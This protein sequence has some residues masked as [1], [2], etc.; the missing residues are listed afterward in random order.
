MAANDFNLSLRNA[1]DT[2]NIS[3]PTSPI[4]DEQS[5]LGFDPATGLPKFFG[6]D[7]VAAV[8]P[9][10][11]QGVPGVVGPQGPAGAKGDKGEPG[12]SFD[13]EFLDRPVNIA[14]NF[15]LS[16]TRNAWVSYS[17]SLRASTVALAASSESIARLGYS[18]DG[19]STWRYISEAALESTTGLTVSVGEVTDI[20]GSVSG[21]IPAGAVVKIFPTANATGSV[22]LLSYQEVLL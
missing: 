14:T 15:T 22:N 3:R 12:E 5:L 13:L 19:G 2:A 6:F 18:M 21:F 7:D 9:Q 20:R 17:F 11:P 4:P 8:G 16:A 1:T 10:G